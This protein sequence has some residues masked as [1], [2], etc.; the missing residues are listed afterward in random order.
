MRRSNNL[1]CDKAQ[2]KH[3]LKMKNQ[4]K[5][6]KNQIIML[7]CVPLLFDFCYF[8]SCVLFILIWLFYLFISDF[9][10]R[11]YLYEW[12]VCKQTL[13]LYYG[14][15]AYTCVACSPVALVLNVV[16]WQIYVDANFWV[17]LL[18]VCRHLMLILFMLGMEFYRGYFKSRKKLLS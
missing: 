15:I 6:S 9:I 16:Y 7:C 8:H 12:N 2:C 10:V 11:I 1:F 4:W 17:T 5:F 13:F 18:V 14:A 3:K